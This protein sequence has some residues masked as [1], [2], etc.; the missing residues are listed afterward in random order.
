MAARRA[1]GVGAR[2]RP[3]ATAAGGRP[4]T[5]RP[6]DDPRPTTCWQRIV[7]RRR[8]RRRRP[9]AA[10]GRGPLLVRLGT[11]GDLL[12]LGVDEEVLGS[13]VVS[14]PHLPKLCGGLTPTAWDYDTVCAPKVCGG[15][16][17]TTLGH[18]SVP[19]RLGRRGCEG[20]EREVV[21]GRI[22]SAESGRSGATGLHRPASRLYG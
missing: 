21:K 17:S 15:L 13:A 4:A 14:L 3:R 22:L 1:R 11:G 16:T 7:G 5:R 6:T 8:W 9:G 18:R 12:T 20:R 10:H 19:E 2:P